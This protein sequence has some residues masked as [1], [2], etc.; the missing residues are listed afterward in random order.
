MALKYIPSRMLNQRGLR[1]GTEGIH[2][3]VRL[4]FRVFG[5]CWCRRFYRGPKYPNGGLVFDTNGNLYGTTIQGGRS[6]SGDVFRLSPD[7]NGTWTTLS[8]FS[9]TGEDGLNPNCSLVLDSNGDLYGTTLLGG[10]SDE[11]CG[12][13]DCGTVFEIT[14]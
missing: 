6:G 10:P 8:L 12:G 1:L 14:P 5:A 13:N 11:G 4:C 7:K 2:Q 9:F 3:Y